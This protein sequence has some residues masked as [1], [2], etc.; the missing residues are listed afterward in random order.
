ML[1]RV[2]CVFIS[3]FGLSA[4]FGVYSGSL[5]WAQSTYC[6]RLAEEALELER[7][8]PRTDEMI[9]GVD[10]VLLAGEYSLPP[11]TYISLRPG[12]T[13]FGQDGFCQRAQ[14]DL[15]KKAAAFCY[16]QGS[17]YYRYRAF[18]GGDFC[19]FS[20]DDESATNTALALGIVQ[21]N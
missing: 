17:Q 13:L 16:C 15:S 9:L 8:L 5:V 20:F 2:F 18:G 11:A 12:L 7:V 4:I 1:R 6:E 3:Y 19:E 21:C 10:E 14:S